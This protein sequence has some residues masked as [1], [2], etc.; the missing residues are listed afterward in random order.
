MLF[1][2]K[3]RMVCSLT[4]LRWCD[5]P[6]LWNSLR[7]RGFLIITPYFTVFLLPANIS[8]IS[9]KYQR[10]HWYPKIKG[11]VPG[12]T[13]LNDFAL[14]QWLCL[15]FREIP[16]EVV[17]ELCVCLCGRSCGVLGMTGIIPT[18]D[19][20][21]APQRQPTALEKVIVHSELERTDGELFWAD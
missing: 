11:Q 12:E 15:K 10:S 9:C 14:T 17:K 20:F 7:V 18:W 2:L 21:T 8:N 1:I 6:V 3:V 19:M 13:W 4:K 5:V 16:L